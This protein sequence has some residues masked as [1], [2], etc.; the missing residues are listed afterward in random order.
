MKLPTIK[1]TITINGAR[2]LLGED[3]REMSDKE[4]LRLINDL[5]FIARYAIKQFKELNQSS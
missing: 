2:K 3:A 4:V 5:D 1:P